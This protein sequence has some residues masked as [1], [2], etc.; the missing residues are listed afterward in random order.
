VDDEGFHRRP[1]VWHV[2]HVLDQLAQRVH[3]E[4]QWLAS[5]P[6]LPER[7]PEVYFRPVVAGDLVLNGS[8]AALAGQ[9]RANYDDAAAIEMESA[10]MAHAA[11]LNQP[12]PSIA[13]RGISDTA[14]GDKNATDRVGWQA[15]A[16]R[17][18]AAFAMMLVAEFSGRAGT[19][20]RIGLNE[21]HTAIG[22]LADAEADGRQLRRTVLAKF[23][24]PAIPSPAERA[25]ELLDWLAGLER[26]AR[27]D[28]QRAVPVDELDTL[29]REIAKAREE[30][31]RLRTAAEGLFDRRLELRGRLDVVHATANRLRLT[32][33]KPG[34]AIYRRA[35]D[36]LWTQPCDL[37]AAFEA[38][39]AYQ[40]WVTDRRGAPCR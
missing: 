5:L 35:H 16:A 39:R 40:K 36:L 14:S 25:E 6:D 7:P 24:D 11:A 19:D 4:R 27:E 23:A 22:E 12:L 2:S 9:I 20:R 13:V 10:G 30:I 34:E 31:A 3:R 15:R 29:E 8:G 26:L 33:D 32:E 28:G 1:K 17:N 38:V 21:L 18:A 37:R